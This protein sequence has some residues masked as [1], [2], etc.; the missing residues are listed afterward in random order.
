MSDNPYNDNAEL[1]NENMWNKGYQK[2]RQEFQK[3]G[4]VLP[5]KCKVCLGRIF[6][7][8]IHIFVCV[9]I[10]SILAILVIIVESKA[11]SKELDG[12]W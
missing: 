8:L 2:A 6:K 5:T 12:A 9:F 11:A 4:G 7:H 10:F 1:P 3:R